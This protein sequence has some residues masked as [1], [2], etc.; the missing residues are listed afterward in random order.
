MKPNVQLF[1]L[2]RSNQGIEG[3]LVYNDFIYRILELP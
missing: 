3:L 2:K 1:R